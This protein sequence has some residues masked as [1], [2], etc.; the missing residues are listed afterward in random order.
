MPYSYISLSHKTHFTFYTRNIVILEAIYAEPVLLLF[1]NAHLFQINSLI[2]IVFY[3][4]MECLLHFVT[5]CYIFKM[6]PE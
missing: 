2:I 3:V 6:N 5:Q 1:I 4:T